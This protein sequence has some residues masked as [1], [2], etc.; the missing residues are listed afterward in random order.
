MSIHASKYLSSTQQEGIADVLSGGAGV[1]QTN[2]WIDK[3]Q[4][5]DRSDE[6]ADK[7]RE[8]DYNA[9]MSALGMD[10]LSQYKNA[11]IDPATQTA[12]DNRIAAERAQM[13]QHM[14]ETGGTVSTTAQRGSEAV[15]ADRIGM[16]EAE[17]NRIKQMHWDAAVKALGLS[18]HS[19]QVLASMNEADRQQAME[20][21][22]STMSVM[23]GTAG[24]Y[25]GS[26][27]DKSAVD[28]YVYQQ[29]SNTQP[30]SN[31]VDSSGGVDTGT[32]STQLY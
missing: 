9:Q 24:K 15:S 30:T 12:I 11:A 10:E 16:Q 19:S 5:K 3:S 14:S 28:A 29:S 13:R 22:N 20:I 31:I 17:L 27:T 1:A 18:D 23:G 7:Q 2:K 21:Y 8:A 6:N 26:S 32:Q 4:K 25:S